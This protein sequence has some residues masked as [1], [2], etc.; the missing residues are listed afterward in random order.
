MHVMQLQISGWV[1]GEGERAASARIASSWHSYAFV[2][3]L[4]RSHYAHILG[5][6]KPHL[7]LCSL[8][9]LSPSITIWHSQ[10]LTDWESMQAQKY[11]VMQVYT[12]TQTVH[13]F[14]TQ[15]HSN[16]TCTPSMAS[17]SAISSHYR[18]LHTLLYCPM[19]L[20][21]KFCLHFSI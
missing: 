14:L 16:P 5:I 3:I 9:C 17:Q 7:K 4:Q 15:S 13:K 1:W 2:P 12:Y 18:W 21:L 11:H 20:I 6:E 8:H 19:V 10:L